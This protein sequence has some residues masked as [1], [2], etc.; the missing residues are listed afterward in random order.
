MTPIDL[1]FHSTASDG[2]LAPA[3]V[4]R[5]AAERGATLLA[6]TDH[7]CTAGWPK[8]RSPQRNAACRS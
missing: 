4:I 1:H 7:D 2:G 6:L 8:R 3:E 5:R